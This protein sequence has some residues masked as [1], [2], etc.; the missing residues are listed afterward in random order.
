MLGGRTQRSVGISKLDLLLLEMSFET[1]KGNT[2]DVKTLD[3]QS[4][5]L[6]INFGKNMMKNNLLKNFLDTIL[7][8]EELT[9]E[10]RQTALKLRDILD[11]EF[12]K[13]NI[14]V[15]AP[16]EQRTVN[17]NGRDFYIS[18]IEQVANT[19]MRVDGSLG[20]IA[21]IKELIGHFGMGL[22]QAKELSEI[23]QR[24]HGYTYE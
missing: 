20:K 23:M 24:N 1:V 2:S 16:F 22:V 5:I 17:Y 12:A 10:I 4:S 14:A 15:I 13:K 11:G 7:G 19:A 3:G 6:I 18:D 21:F 8:A 9:S